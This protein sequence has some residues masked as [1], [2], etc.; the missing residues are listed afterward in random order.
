MAKEHYGFAKG[1]SVGTVDD[2][3]SSLQLHPRKWKEP[4]RQ[5]PQRFAFQAKG[6]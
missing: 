3:T 4:C 6:F 5:F 2:E 1:Y